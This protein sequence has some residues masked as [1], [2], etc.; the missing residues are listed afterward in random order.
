M[1]VVFIS[2]HA[3]HV[4]FGS[5]G[6]FATASSDDD[7]GNSGAGGVCV[8]GDGG[9]EQAGRDGGEGGKPTSPG[10]CVD[11]RGEDGRSGGLE[12]ERCT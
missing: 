8:G 6:E 1:G 2:G 11:Y 9:V 7:V 10:A 12:G 4:Q 3:H 5:G